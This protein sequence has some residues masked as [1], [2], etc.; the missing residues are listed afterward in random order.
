MQFLSA[1]QCVQ[2][3]CQARGWTEA[4]YRNVAIFTARHLKSADETMLRSLKF[5]MRE[6]EYLRFDRS[7]YD[8]QPHRQVGAGSCR[9]FAFAAA[10]DCHAFCLLSGAL[11]ARF[12][13]A[14]SLE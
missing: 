4:D 7:I 12:V 9:V 1:D 13:R 14:I 3:D 6:G 11:H 10:H 8:H 5:D 2:A